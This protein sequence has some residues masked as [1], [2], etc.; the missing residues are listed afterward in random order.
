MKTNKKN[1]TNKNNY[2]ILKPKRKNLG[3][4]PLALMFDTN[5]PENEYNKNNLNTRRKKKKKRIK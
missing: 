1:K 3:N 5:S 2:M 4:D